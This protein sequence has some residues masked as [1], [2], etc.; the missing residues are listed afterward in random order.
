VPS[1]EPHIAFA[2]VP[3]AELSSADVRPRW[4]A[5]WI[6]QNARRFTQDSADNPA[7]PDWVSVM[8]D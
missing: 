8:S 7:R 2:W 5:Q 1:L 3:I 6:V 4:L